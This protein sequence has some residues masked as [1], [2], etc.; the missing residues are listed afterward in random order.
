MTENTRTT[1]LN[2]LVISSHG[3]PPYVGPIFPCPHDRPSSRSLL[4]PSSSSS[5]SCSMLLPFLSLPL[6][7]RGPGLLTCRYMTA[8]ARHSSLWTPRLVGRGIHRQAPPPPPP[9]PHSA[10]SC[11]VRFPTALDV[12]KA[13]GTRLRLL[14]GPG[15][16]AG[17]V[18][19]PAECTAGPS[20]AGHCSSTSVRASLETFSQGRRYMVTCQPGLLRGYGYTTPSGL[21]CMHAP[22]AADWRRLSTQRRLPPS[23]TVLWLSALQATVDVRCPSSTRSVP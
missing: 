4:L 17:N 7:S 18:G 11:I 1:S 22:W 16:V 20:R 3:R 12:S 15:A 10:N 8:S 2:T 9:P 13:P 14:L 19:Q 6:V 21:P 5:S 23:P